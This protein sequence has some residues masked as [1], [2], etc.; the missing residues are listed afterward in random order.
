MELW[1]MK[2][3]VRETHRPKR[4]QKRVER[5]MLLMAFLMHKNR[6]YEETEGN[7]VLLWLIQ[8]LFLRN[9]EG[10]DQKQRLKDV[11]FSCQELNTL[12]KNQM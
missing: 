2:E 9:H 10:K 3:G 1:T 5:D 12:Q 4:K 7:Y 11:L 8:V 6:K